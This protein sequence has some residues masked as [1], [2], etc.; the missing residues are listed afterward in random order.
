MPQNIFGPH[1][2][3]ILIIVLLVF[4]ATRLPTLA[5]SMGQS[6]RIFKKEMKQSKLEDQGDEVTTDATV[7]EEAPATNRDAA[8]RTPSK[9]VADDLDTPKNNQR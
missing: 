1:L 6:V 7:A 9:T 8:P 3:V 2:I 5:K 4:G